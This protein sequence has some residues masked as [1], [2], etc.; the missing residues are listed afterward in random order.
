MK[1]SKKR[2]TMCL[3]FASILI[4]SGCGGGSSNPPAPDTTA[5]I[6]ANTQTTYDVMEGLSLE[7]NASAMDDRGGLVIYSKDHAEFTINNIGILGF[8]AQPINSDATVSVTITATDEA[9]NSTE[10]TITVRVKDKGIENRTVMPER[11]RNFRDRGAG[12]V[13]NTHTGFLWQKGVSVGKSWDIAK[14]YCNNLNLAGKTDWE[15]PTRMDLNKL[16]NYTSYPVGFDAELN[17]TIDGAAHGEYWANEEIDGTHSWSISFNASGGDNK[18]LKTEEILT[19]CVSGTHKD[20]DFEQRV[21]NDTN[22][23]WKVEDANITFVNANCTSPY[24]LPT[25]NELLSIV[26]FEPITVFGVSG[27]VTIGEVNVSVASLENGFGGHIWT[28][29][30]YEENDINK[31]KVLYITPA[32]ISDGGIE[33]NATA[34]I[35]C[36]K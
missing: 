36:V 20:A 29:T 26:E 34:G 12:T 11:G 3:S 31:T 24:R 16:I 17:S 15:L 18:K 1:L 27:N 30:R 14:G 19:R 25:F 9:N 33:K 22:L 2:V 21:D 7:I 13:V 6:F 28:S 23:E 35:V 8:F 4:M 10:K 5:P 32:E